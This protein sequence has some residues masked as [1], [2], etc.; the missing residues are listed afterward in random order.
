MKSIIIALH[1]LP[2]A[3][4]HYKH[5]SRVGCNSDRLN[6]LMS[7]AFQLLIQLLLFSINVR[8]ECFSI[9]G[10]SECLEAKDEKEKNAS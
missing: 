9:S 7:I 6:S 10:R 5:F 8:F 4:T 1:V 3:S 2:Y